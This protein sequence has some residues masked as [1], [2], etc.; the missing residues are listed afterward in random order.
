MNESK[1]STKLLKETDWLKGGEVSR[2][3]VC[4]TISPLT[5][6]AFWVCLTV[7]FLTVARLLHFCSLS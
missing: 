1:N 3:W 5:K 6:M 4:L 2:F 7:S